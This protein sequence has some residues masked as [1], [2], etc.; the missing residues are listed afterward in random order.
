MM[1]HRA[2][3]L[4]ATIAYKYGGNPSRAKRRE[5]E[6]DRRRETG[7]KLETETEKIEQGRESWR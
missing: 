6:R 4:L 5:T 1:Y 2:G 7:R 3:A